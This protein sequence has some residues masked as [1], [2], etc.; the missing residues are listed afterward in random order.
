L[1]SEGDC[2]YQIK[3]P[4]GKLHD[5]F[6]M[7]DCNYLGVPWKIQVSKLDMYK[8]KVDGWLKGDKREKGK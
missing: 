6:T 5:D 4:H 2:G 7:G 3:S 8:D 1:G